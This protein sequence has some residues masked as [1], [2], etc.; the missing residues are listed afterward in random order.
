MK[1]IVVI[2]T[3]GGCG[4]TTVS[5]NLASYY[6][7]KGFNTAL[8][9]YDPQGSSMRW[10]K[11]REGDMS[12]I[13]GVVAHK[14][15]AKAVTMSWQLRLPA[16]TERVIIDT[17]PGL[18]GPELKEQL[19]GADKILIPV[20]PS[21]LDIFA[22]ADFI[23]DLLLDVK[24]RLNQTS[25]GIVANRVRKNTVAFQSLERF[26]SSLNI[27]V[28]A[29]LRDTQNYL[30]ATEEGMGI[31]ELKGKNVYLDRTHWKGIVEWLDRNDQNL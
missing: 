1:R 28:V 23:R 24:V 2:N 10:L 17:P 11:L 9:D 25:I 21:P 31:H 4:K 15:S 13:Y 8:F 7:S 18:K 19:K 16:E 29:R 3:K 12:D 20:L 5:T 27:P 26:L 6:A 30:R 22:T 14:N